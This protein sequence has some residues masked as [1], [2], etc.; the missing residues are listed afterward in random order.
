MVE[1]VFFGNTATRSS[2]QVRFLWHCRHSFLRGVV[3]CK[4][5]FVLPLRPIIRQETQ[6]NTS[7]LSPPPQVFLI[8]GTPL[9]IDEALSW[10][11]GGR[12]YAK[13]IIPAIGSAAVLPDEPRVLGFVAGSAV[14]LGVYQHLMWEVVRGQEPFTL[15]QV[16]LERVSDVSIFLQPVVS[17]FLCLW[18][19]R[20]LDLRTCSLVT[21]FFLLDI[22]VLE[23]VHNASSAALRWECLNCLRC[24]FQFK[25]DERVHKTCLASYTEGCLV[26]T[27]RMARLQI[28]CRIFFAP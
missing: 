21:L 4:P 26:R 1:S 25:T 12:P 11:L 2:G 27:S 23:G 8:V 22:W 16:R 3:S 9:S 19:G 7:P 28:G 18:I 13:Y 20:T 14:L 5:L 10:R 24:L 15:G 17:A 6:S